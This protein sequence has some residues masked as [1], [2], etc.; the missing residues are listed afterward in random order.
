MRGS[1]HEKVCAE[2][3]WVPFFIKQEKEDVFPPIPIKYDFFAIH[4]LCLFYK[5]L[6]GATDLHSLIPPPTQTTI[7]TLRSHN[8]QQVTTLRRGSEYLQQT[9]IPSSSKLWNGLSNVIKESKSYATFKCYAKDAFNVYFMGQK[10]PDSTQHSF[11]ALTDGYGKDAFNVY[12]RGQKVAD[13]TQ[14]S[15]SCLGQG[16]GK[17]AFN[18]YFMGQKIPDATQH[19]FQ[20][21]GN[22]Y[23]KDAFNAYYYGKKVGGAN[24]C[25]FHGPPPPDCFPPHDPFYHG[26]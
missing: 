21:M 23:A 16:Y 15:F 8:T 13:A 26:Q 9:F 14:H 1:S 18:V 7:M 17:D 19:S 6:K 11:V 5:I 22:G 2:L 10:I 3:G 20:L 25:N 4:R 12:F 24:T